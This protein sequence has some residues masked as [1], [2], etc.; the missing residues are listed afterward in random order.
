MPTSVNA[1]HLFSD[2]LYQLNILKDYRKSFHYLEDS[3]YVVPE[4]IPYDLPQL[5]RESLAYD[6]KEVLDIVEFALKEVEY[7]LNMG[8]SLVDKIST[9]S[10]INYEE[11][12]QMS[13]PY[14]ELKDEILKGIILELNYYSYHLGLLKDQQIRLISSTSQI[15]SQV[16]ERRTEINIDENFRLPELKIKAKTVVLDRYQSGLL[17]QYLKEHNVIQDFSNIALAK[18]V[19]LLTGHSDE[20]LRREVFGAIDHVKK[21]KKKN[22]ILAQGPNHNL[23]AVKNILN[24]II[25]NIESDMKK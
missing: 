14:P 9:Y 24:S 19:S 4:S 22:K 15:G 3:N 21:D 2:F 8:E 6:P 1:K 11:I 5:S 17:F 13:T 18:I 7:L 10:T 23:T 16:I 12:N 20:T 25:L